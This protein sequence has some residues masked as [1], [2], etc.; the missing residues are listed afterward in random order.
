MGLSLEDWVSGFVMGGDWAYA[1]CFWESAEEHER[2]A[3]MHD[4]AAA[5]WEEHGDRAVAVLER[6]AAALERIAAGLERDRAR[7]F[8]QRG[9]PEPAGE[10]TRSISRGPHRDVERIALT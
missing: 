3:R 8:A 6:R 9:V 1:V 2:S 4:D 10:R 5:L 7:L